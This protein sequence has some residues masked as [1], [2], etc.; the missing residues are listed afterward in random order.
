MEYT[1]ARSPLTGRIYAGPSSLRSKTD[2]TN[3]FLGAMIQWLHDEDN[4]LNITV[5][6]GKTYRVVLHED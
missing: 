2:V 1:L 5:S 4:E 6:D 3:Q